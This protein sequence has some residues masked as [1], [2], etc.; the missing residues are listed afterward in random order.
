MFL[1]SKRSSFLVQSPL[2]KQELNVGKCVIRVER[3]VRACGKVVNQNPFTYFIS[4]KTKS[5]PYSISF[6]DQKSMIGR[7]DDIL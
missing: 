4:F 3:G 5:K 7:L 2:G 1:L 6:Y